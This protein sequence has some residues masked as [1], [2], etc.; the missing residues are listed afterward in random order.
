MPA[1]YARRSAPVL[2]QA[3]ITLGAPVRLG[4]TDEDQLERLLIPEALF[5]LFLG[6]GI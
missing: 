6:Q 3:R 5:T 1:K 4:M 2:G